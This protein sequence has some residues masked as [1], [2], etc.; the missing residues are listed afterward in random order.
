MVGH[1]ASYSRYLKGK[2]HYIT[3]FKILQFD[4]AYIELIENYPCNSKDELNREEGKYQREMKC[5]N[6]RV[7]NRTKEEKNKK[8]NEKFRCECGSKYTYKHK[9]RHLKTKIHK[10]YIDEMKQ[11]DT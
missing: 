6:K 11:D 7:E 4:D 3:S 5:V 8:T 9:Q 10:K 2:Y 1:R